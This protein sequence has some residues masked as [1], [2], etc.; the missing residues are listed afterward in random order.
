MKQVLLNRCLR[1]DGPLD[2]RPPHTA[3]RFPSDSCKFRSK[4]SLALSYRAQVFNEPTRSALRLKFV[5]ARTPRPVTRQVFEKYLL[6]A[7]G[8]LCW[9]HWRLFACA[10]DQCTRAHAFLQ[11]LHIQA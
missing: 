7:Q 6:V 5:L 2:P 4:R 10:A 11:K 3:P 9:L 1:S 8:R